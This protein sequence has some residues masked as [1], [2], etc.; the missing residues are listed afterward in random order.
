M[1]NKKQELIDFLK[2]VMEVH[3]NKNGMLEICAGGPEPEPTVEYVVKRYLEKISDNKMIKQKDG[4]LSG[5]I[6]IDSGS[7]RTLVIND[8]DNCIHFGCTT[9]YLNLTVW[10]D[11]ELIK[12][13]IVGESIEVIYKE[14][15]RIIHYSYPDQRVFKVIYSCKDGKWNESERIYGTIIPATDESYDFE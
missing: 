13:E 3:T 7:C 9:G 15:S 11:P 14:T 10:N 12:F 5:S 4:D 6:N 2:Y 8:S 1:E